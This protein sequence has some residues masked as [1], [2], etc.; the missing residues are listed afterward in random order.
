M[1]NFTELAVCQ[2][3]LEYIANRLERGCSNL[4][5]VHDSI[6]YGQNDGRE[7]TDGLYFALDGFRMLSEEMNELNGRLMAA[8]RAAES[9]ATAAGKQKGA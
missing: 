8:I 2:S 6:V 9:D 4:L 7:Y 5:A 1:N 3:E